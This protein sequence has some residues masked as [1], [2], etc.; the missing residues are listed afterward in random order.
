MLR[1]SNQLSVMTYVSINPK[2]EFLVHFDAV[3]R[4]CVPSNGLEDA[5]L[6]QF[7]LINLY[8]F[9]SIFSGIVR[10]DKLH[11][12]AE[13]ICLLSNGYYGNGEKTLFQLS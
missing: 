4:V 1:K 10:I 2:N 3:G 7:F 5:T 11:N 9:G 8:L 13:E 6:Q 12:F